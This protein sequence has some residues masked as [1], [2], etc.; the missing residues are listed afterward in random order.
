MKGTKGTVQSKSTKASVQKIMFGVLIAIFCAFCLLC[1]FKAFGGVG[2]IVYRGLLG[3]LGI[4]AYSYLIIGLVISIIIM[5]N[6]KFKKSFSFLVL[7]TTIFAAIIY[8][9]HIWTSSVHFFNSKTFQEYLK[10]TY[11]NT[12]TAGGLLYSVSSYWVMKVV[13]PGGGLI[14]TAAVGLLLIFFLIFPAISANTTYEIPDLSRREQKKL[15]F[16]N[17][18]RIKMNPN[19]HKI[20]GYREP[21]LTV[22]GQ[23]N[24]KF[25]PIKTSGQVKPSKPTQGA[26]GYTPMREGQI[27][28]AKEMAKQVLYSKK[29]SDEELR[30]LKVAINPMKGFQNLGIN[31][32]GYVADV[33]NEFDIEN[34]SVES[35]SSKMSLA[36][37]KEEVVLDGKGRKKVKLS[38]D[39]IKAEEAMRYKGEYMAPADVVAEA[40]EKAESS[41]VMTA[42]EWQS[43]VVEP[44]DSFSQFNK[45]FNKSKVKNKNSVTNRIDETLSERKKKKV[46]LTSDF[47]DENSGKTLDDL[48]AFGTVPAAFE[49]T[50]IT[51]GYLN[52]IKE[53]R[54]YNSFDLD[55]EKKNID[56]DFKQTSLDEILARM[57][58]KKQPVSQKIAIEKQPV[59]KQNNEAA[60]EPVRKRKRFVSL[61]KNLLVKPDERQKQNVDYGEMTMSLIRC[62]ERFNVKA[63]LIKYQEGP[64]FTLFE[65]NV[66]MPAGKSVST[67][68]SYAQDLAM[69]ME[70]DNV[71]ILAPIPGK[72]AVGIEIPNRHRRMVRLSEMLWSKE[73]WDYQ[74]TDV[75]PIG[76][77]IYGRNKF[78]IV[79]QT[80]HLLIAGATGAG[81][82][83]CLNSI[84]VSLLYKSSPEDLRLILIDPKR[85]EFSVYSGIP[86]LLTDDIVCEVEKAYKALNWA[87]QE[88]DR[89]V[90]LFQTYQVRD[91]DDYNRRHEENGVEKLPRIVIVVDELAELL[92]VGKKVVEEAINKIARL[93]RAAGIHLILAT[94][95]PSVDVVS[96]TI[97]NNLPSRIVF[98]V[99]SGADSRTIIDQVGAED[100]LGNGDLLYLN[101]KQQNL[102]RLQNPFVSTDEVRDIVEHLKEHNESYFDQSVQDAIFK[103]E[104]EKP[105]SESYSGG[106]GRDN[107]KLFEALK[108]CSIDGGAVSKSKIQRKLNVGF[109]RAANLYDE[110]LDGGFLEEVEP[111]KY[112]VSMTPQEIDELYNATRNE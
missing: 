20:G 89:R 7:T 65:L 43:E 71:R 22:F 29:V 79:S 74:Q 94:Q 33:P 53:D 108:M 2:E 47:N 35:N 3:G 85:V 88:M 72:N 16:S 1:T 112:I 101:P 18:R 36:D 64:T 95:R 62:L 92:S 11:E 45:F 99:S 55:E 5:T 8:A 60:P 23:D 34:G 68:N 69:Q 102:E 49:S 63:S 93:A 107:E 61:P 58:K 28:S 37:I 96:G 84:I 76:V 80:P 110:M 51:E 9:L 15:G 59:K 10:L 111:G 32:G 38:L 21:A 56:E 42:D 103:D 91:L 30:N 105:E 83:C 100:L 4:A 24:L 6:L 12:N 19:G 44:D 25:I 40:Y 81:K 27:L 70:V 48:G 17:F 66:T 52:K 57:E 109:N 86:H 39:S 82:S 14:L 67:I 46:E 87:V 104:E 26:A 78:G 77:D 75:F 50:K 90:K 54:L 13:T 73:F 97:K 31:N 41:D 106:R 98:R